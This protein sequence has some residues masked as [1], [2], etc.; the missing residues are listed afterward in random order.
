MNLFELQQ[1]S[2]RELQL[3]PHIV[4]TGCKKNNA[5]HLES[6]RET[7]VDFFRI[8]N[9]IDGKYE[10]R[11]DEEDLHL[12]PGDTVLIL[13]G[14]KLSSPKGFLEIGALAWIHFEIDCLDHA[15]FVPGRWSSLNE[16]ECYTIGRI[17][18]LNRSL[19]PSKACEA[20]R[21]LAALQSEL[22]NQGIAF[23]TRVNQLLDELLVAIAR[24]LAKEAN[25]GRDFSKVFF[26]LEKKLRDNLARQWSVEEMAATVG[27]GTTLFNVRVKSYTGFTPTNYLINLRIAEAIKLLRK[28][29]LN[30]TDIALDTGFCSSQHF[31]TTFKKLTG[32]TP[33]EFRKR[34]TGD[35]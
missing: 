14:R 20:S 3:F 30:L 13:P 6:F 12:Y 23:H 31:S 11:V 1:G 33:S 8:Y 34:N 9:I 17:L 27:M 26:Q 5:I 16:S 19:A 32:Y 15:K 35:T 21:I 24:E 29:E 25:P 4:S 22:L 18:L 10:W 28:P 2:S 7:A